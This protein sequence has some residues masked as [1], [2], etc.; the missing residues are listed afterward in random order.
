MGT[1]AG[2]IG[3]D[4]NCDLVAETLHAV[5]PVTR[6]R[7]ISDSGTL[8]PLHTHTEECDPQEVWLG[9]F[10]AWAGVS[11]ESCMAEH[12]D[13]P[14]GCVRSVLRKVSMSK[15]SSSNIAPSLT[16]AYPYMATEFLALHSS[17]DTTIRYCYE[18][19]PEFWQRWREELASVATEISAAL[20]DQAGMFIVNCPFH[21]AIGNAYSNMEVLT[22]AN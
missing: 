18:D 16:T 12:P 5:N 14:R 7:C 15:L 17:T 10:N 13:G 1:S 22:S 11:D 4:A 6:V 2:G 19:T 20:P 21:G 3:T 9:F 8:Y